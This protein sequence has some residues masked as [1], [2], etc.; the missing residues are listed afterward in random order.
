VGVESATELSPQQLVVYGVSGGKVGPPRGGIATKRG[1]DHP[2]PVIGLE[3]L[4][5]LDE[6]QRV[7]GHKVTVGSR[8]WSRSSPCPM[9]TTSRVGHQ[10]S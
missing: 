1:L 6:E 10:L 2:K 8:S 4:S 5:C 7:S 9:A 3:R